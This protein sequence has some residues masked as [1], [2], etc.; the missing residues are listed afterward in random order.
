MHEEV[1]PN[2]KSSKFDCP[3]THAI[4]LVSIKIDDVIKTDH[5]QAQSIKVISAV[6]FMQ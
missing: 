2:S 1:K 5:G 6:K 3:Q 4:S